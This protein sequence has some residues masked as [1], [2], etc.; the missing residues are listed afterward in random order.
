MPGTFNGTTLKITAT[1]TAGALLPD[2]ADS[3]GN[4]TNV[5]GITMV[6]DDLYCVKTSGT[7]TAM[8]KIPKYA[9]TDSGYSV[10][11]NLKVPY[12]S[13]GLSKIGET[14][15][16]LAETYV[17]YGGTTRIIKTTTAG[18]K[19][20]EYPI[21]SIFPNGAIGIAHTGNG[22]EFFVLGYGANAAPAVKR[23]QIS[24]SQ[25]VEK[26]SFTINNSG[27]G[28]TYQLQDIYYHMDYG[29][30]LLTNDA[31]NTGKNRILLIDYKAGTSAYTPSAVIEVDLSTSQYSQYNLE[32]ICMKGGNLV[33]ASNIILKNGGSEDRISIIKGIKFANGTYSF[34]C[35]MTEGAKVPNKD[36]GGIT[37]T[38]FGTIAMGGK[39]LYGIK[40]GS[41]N[42]Y[43]SAAGCV[44]GVFTLPDYDNPKQK[45]PQ[46]I[47][48]IAPG[49]KEKCLYHANGM[50]YYDGN[51]YIACGEVKD[52]GQNSFVKMSTDGTE[53][54]RYLNGNNRANAIS[55]YRGKQFLVYTETKN[56]KE[57]STS[58]AICCLLIGEFSGNT[59]NV[60][61]T[62]YFLN[63]GYETIQDIFHDD[64][65]G[66]F[67]VTC[68][69]VNNYTQ[70]NR[71]LHLTP[72][73]RKS[74]TTSGGEKRNVIIPDFAFDNDGDKT[75]FVSFELESL[76]LDPLTNNLIAAV[77]TVNLSNTNTTA[78]GIYRFSTVEFLQQN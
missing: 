58:R 18:K 53:F 67:I 5:A 44:A 48:N 41:N 22:E 30:F 55:H 4:I 72:T 14:L 10:V 42:R 77:N 71:V 61:Q 62:H 57:Q 37:A 69:I 25:A 9:E 78:D 49:N 74:L 40:A 75:K 35:G 1:P 11:G 52:V 7:K 26:E 3:S 73:R 43:E 29:L 59:F 12:F 47:I 54:I 50:D 20:G 70:A 36:I 19:Q 66:T 60:S 32:S 13:L 23:I 31:L 33:L 63:T 39:T 24:G 27:Y 56:Q 6:G 28:Y 34:T 45:T 8:L 68:N 2:V 38:N 15:Y 17:G 16:M 51:L 64:N 76:A 46:K 65:Y 21:N